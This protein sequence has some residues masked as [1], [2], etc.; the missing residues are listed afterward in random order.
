MICKTCET[1]ITTT[2]TYADLYVQCPRCGSKQVVRE[3]PPG[4]EQERCPR[5]KSTTFA[6]ES[7]KASDPRTGI[8]NVAAYWNACTVCW[9]KWDGVAAGDDAILPAGVVARGAR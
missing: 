2:L 6:R 8:R 3:L 4:P 1:E 7:G 9:H 5:C